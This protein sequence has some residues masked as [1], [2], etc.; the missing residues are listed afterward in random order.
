MLPESIFWNMLLN[1]LSRFYTL[2]QRARLLKY[3]FR[4][5]EF[6]WLFPAPSSFKTCPINRD[7]LAYLFSTGARPTKLIEIMEL[8]IEREVEAGSI[9]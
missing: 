7:N 2:L 5:G 1:V 8:D 3:V 6:G 4:A 9:V